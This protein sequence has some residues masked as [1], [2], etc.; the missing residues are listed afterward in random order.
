MYCYQESK[1]AG[2]PGMGATWAGRGMDDL[3]AR[4]G[5]IETGRVESRAG[6]VV[7]RATPS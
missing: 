3:L 1:L 2:R 4:H 5:I 7:I 6:Y